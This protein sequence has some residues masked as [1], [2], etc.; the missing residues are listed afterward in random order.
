MQIR[1]RQ[2]TTFVCKINWRFGYHQFI[3]F[4]ARAPR[5]SAADQ[6]HEQYKFCYAISNAESC[7]EER[8]QETE[9]WLEQTETSSCWAL[10]ILRIIWTR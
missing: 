2:K 8:R 6:L 5:G 3:G 4:Q 9:E 7:E 10:G 1:F